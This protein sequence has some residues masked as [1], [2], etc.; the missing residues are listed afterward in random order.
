MQDLAA[1]S[2]IEL[3]AAV[4]LLE[5]DGR[6]VRMANR[7][8][9]RTLRVPGAH[10]RT[11]KA[12]DPL[13][14]SV[15]VDEALACAISEARSSPSRRSLW[16]RLVDGQPSSWTVQAA[17][18]DEGVMVMVQELS[19]PSTPPSPGGQSLR[20]IH[21]RLRN[22]LQGV[23]GLLERADRDSESAVAA[24]DRAVIE[25]RV[26]GAVQLLLAQ[27][28]PSVLAAEWVDTTLRALP[29]VGSISMDPACRARSTP[30]SDVLDLN[31]RSQQARATLWSHLPQGEQKVAMTTPSWCVAVDEA[32]SLT[33]CVTALVLEV[34]RV[35]R[36]APLA[37]GLRQ[38]A[39]GITLEINGP[40]TPSTS[41]DSLPKDREEQFL[42]R[43][44]SFLPSR[45][46]ALLHIT[47]GREVCARLHI[48]PPCVWDPRQPVP[49]SPW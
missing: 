8:A 43:I 7:A 3:P 40:E 34:T 15:R 4:L 31:D 23:V 27:E 25:L 30:G 45:G 18:L 14:T 32:L 24:L 44:G 21:H 6:T 38:E 41:T 33:F 17:P 46:G 11:V 35:C 2:L 10:D 13:A 47:P 26:L 22:S 20:E 37:C 49:Q 9:W 39:D 29:M 16:L 19:P 5:S 12:F 36:G 1:R 48:W 28:G 42:E